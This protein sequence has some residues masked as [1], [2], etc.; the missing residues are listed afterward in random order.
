MVSCYLGLDACIRAWRNTGQ[1]NSPERL[2][3]PYQKFSAASWREPEG[4]L[5]I[6]LSVD[7][8]SPPLRFR[9]RAIPFDLCWSW[10]AMPARKDL[11]QP[12]IS[13]R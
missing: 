12:E 9:R 1:G 8:F 4:A 6:V 5:A 3:S 11:D 2:V 10:L 7:A 13:I